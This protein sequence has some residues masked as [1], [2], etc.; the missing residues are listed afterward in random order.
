[1]EPL[2]AGTE[3]AGRFRLIR[4]VGRGALGEV[5]LAEDLAAGRRVALKFP[6]RDA[7]LAILREGFSRT[8]KLVH[9]AIVRLYE[10]I[11]QPRPALVMQFV[12]GSDA[13]ALRGAG[14]RTILAA[15]GVVAEALEYAHRQGVV[16]RDLKPA[17]ILHDQQGRLL[18]TDFGAAAGGGTL[19][20][21]SPQQLDGAPPVVSDDV[22]GFGAL[23]YELLAGEPLFHPE[24]TPERI[25]SVVPQIPR[26]D[27]SGEPLPQ[28]LRRL[29]GALLEK[30]PVQRPPGMAAVRDALEQI[31]HD[32]PELPAARAAAAVIEPLAR[33]RMP[34]PAP[35]T[36]SGAGLPARLVFAALVVL[37]GLAAVVVFYLP[38]LV[39]ERTPAVIATVAPSPVAP[40]VATEPA[41]AVPQDEIDEALGAF[42]R[43]D[44]E[45]RKLNAERWAGEEWTKLRRLAE[46]GDAAY[47][48]RESAA[49]LDLYRQAGATAG[50]LLARAPVVLEEALRE[51]R[52]ALAA[53]D[54]TAAQAR[55]E[56]ALAIDTGHVEARRGLERAKNLPGLRALLTQATSAEAAGNTTADRNAA[57]GFYRQAAALDPES[58]E[59]AAGVAR[60]QGGLAADAFATQM[61]RGFA[62]Q[63]RG[64]FEA[65]ADA[66]SAALRVRPGDAQAQ[67]AL[68]QLQADQQLA[69]LVGLQQQAGALEKEERWNEALSRYESVLAVDPALVT[70]QEGAARARTRLDLDRRMRTEI[71]SADRFNDDAVLARARSTLAAARAIAD[72]GPVLAAQVVELG[73]PLELA[74]IPVTVRFDSD[75]LTEVT[76]YKVGR[77]GMFSSRSLELR[78]GL[79]TVVGSRAGYRDVRR[80]V[81]VE[82]GREGLSVS[83]RCEEPI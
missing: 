62:A 22:Y 72:A 15:L 18:L 73:R 76:I 67:S 82:P 16:H 43:Q 29:L 5:W 83:V 69:R 27:L 24:V 37:V 51:G 33:E 20:A 25:R 50:Q 32:F 79:Y 64:D 68:T 34:A 11:D 9:P 56:M 35:A 14:F 10:F 36:A 4:A 54:E 59:A 23:L 48:R 8:A 52:K 58:A 61:A 80:N 2:T 66:F 55:F 60:L 40:P 57:L 31:L 41:A 46:E 53:G 13:G 1:M 49:T 74:V 7:A 44:D 77:L 26:T 65:A 70:A 21:M 28:P 81:R 19:P 17:N 39:R 42:L 38:V 75:N 3:L 47:R 6:L 78:P 71:T 12:E 63:A 45:L 30:S